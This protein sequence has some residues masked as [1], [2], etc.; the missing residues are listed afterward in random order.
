M[1]LKLI[2]IH[3]LITAL[4]GYCG[5]EPGKYMLLTYALSGCLADDFQNISYVVTYAYTQ[6][7]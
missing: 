2:V 5:L 3:T 6:I 4:D 1:T 7:N